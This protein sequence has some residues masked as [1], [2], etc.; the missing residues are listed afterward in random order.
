[1][2][3]PHT[4]RG[5]SIAAVVLVA[6]GLFLRPAN[7]QLKADT[8][9][10][11]GI[12]L[13]EQAARI[14]AVRIS[15]VDV[16]RGL[17]RSTTSGPD[18]AYR[19]PL[20]PP[21][22]YRLDFSADGFRR[23][24]V[25]AVDVRVGET[26]KVDVMLTVAGVQ[27]FVEV[28]A[29]SP[30]I[31]P[32]AV[33][34]TASV[35]STVL[36]TFPINRRNYLDLALLTP[37]VTQTT[38]L[39][40]QADFRIPIAPTSGLS[41]A[42]TNG[43]G[44]MFLVDGIATN[45]AT[46]N[47]RPSVP[48][49]AVEEFQVTRGNASA[50][51]GGAIGGILSIVTRSGSN[52]LRGTAF[53][54]LRNSHLDARNY[55]DPGNSDFSRVQSGGSAGGPIAKDRAFFFGALEH[56]HRHETAFVS[57]LDD[58]ESLGRPTASQLGVLDFFRRSG[59]PV[60]VG[61]AP[62][63]QAV[64]TPN[65]NPLVMPLV[66]SNAG[67][68]PTTGD[69]VQ[70]TMRVD[71]RW[72]SDHRL[73]V[74]GNVT[75]Q[76]DENAKFGALV[77][78]SHGNS[79]RW[80][81]WDLVAADTYVLNP[82]WVGVSRVSFARARFEMQPNDRIG[83]EL[84]I[85]GFGSFGRD[86][87]LPFVQRER[88]IEMEQA[89]SY[90]AAKHSVK[91]GVDLNTIHD[92]GEVDTFFGGRF[93]FGEALPL[94][95][96]VGSLT[97]DPAALAVL[98]TAPP[99]VVAALSQ[100]I[101]SLQ[102]YSLG[103]PVAYVQAFGNSASES[104]RKQH[105][106]FVEYTYRPGSSVSVV[107]GLREQFN[108]N[109][110]LRSVAY[111][112]PR[113]GM[114]WAPNG[115]TVVRG[116]YGRFHS[117]VDLNIAYSAVQLKR[118]D[119]TNVFIPLSGVPGVIN[120]LTGLPVTSGDVYQS[121]LAR[122]I[123]G[124]QTATLSDLAPLGINSRIPFPV[125][126]GV[127]DQYTSPTSQQASAEID[128]AWGGFRTSAAYNYSRTSH[129]WRTRDHNLRR[130]GTRSD[131][132]PIF[133]LVDP[134]LFNNFV[135]ESAGHASYHAL[136]LQL[137]RSLAR[138]WSVGGHYTLSTAV[139]DVTDFNIDYAPH[140]QL[141]PAAERGPSAFDERHRLLVNVVMEVPMR[142]ARSGWTIAGVMRA[143][144]GRPFNVL[145]GFDNLGDGEVN[146]HRPIGISRNSGRGPAFFTT[147]L[148]VSKGFPV[149]LRPGAR[150]ELT[151]EAFNLFNRTNFQSVNNIVGSLTAA[152][153]PTPLVGHVGNPT[154]PLAFTSAYEAR[155]LQLGLRLSF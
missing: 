140:N 86:N 143:Q 111:L 115:T 105:S 137:N 83:P 44:N 144:S 103:L 136:I 147:D 62:V 151:A 152:Q 43:R 135:I 63:L 153:L 80:H 132:L 134:T 70:G 88:Y 87:L 146:T 126:G 113:I 139:D 74:R 68:F 75:H 79:T 64:L 71:R 97:T 123:L 46:G 89:F 48:Q 31:D 8:G 40:G 60:L 19:F 33:S 81:G 49:E 76:D 41:F 45:G 129:L 17:S 37:G 102:S 11:V 27:T 93:I 110:N 82:R 114:S 145:T 90:S 1:M 65:T 148:R 5:A 128:R 127:E 21:A 53:T 12:V 122:R 78:Y 149:A 7:A 13:D 29:H 85:G 101:S 154:T 72:L 16:E 95:F 32:E 141:D 99:D 142:S 109:T 6:T 9:D 131:G 54:Q 20:L 106:A 133:G 38:A 47:V 125:T 150:V 3:S 4:T 120:P 91:A 26:A 130:I 36:E 57:I 18:G 24:T 98:A 56:Q 23:V 112:D 96:L 67:A 59:T 52:E 39:A 155:Q 121:L 92:A 77:G 42:G 10:I 15:A 30:T 107:G 124:Q 22:R 58:P 119:V 61:L 51:F 2:T 66:A 55:F 69:S 118:S 117:W 108:A 116:A 138:G 35:G 84:L 28:K 50:E 73:F 14:P 94:G 100:P 25:D 104:S 34:Q